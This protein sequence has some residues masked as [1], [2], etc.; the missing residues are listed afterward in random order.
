[1]FNKIK[2]KFIRLLSRPKS[3]WMLS[4][5]F[6]GMSVLLQYRKPRF[7]YLLDSVEKKLKTL[8]HYTVGSFMQKSHEFYKFNSIHKV[9]VSVVVT[10]YNKKEIVK[11]VELIQNQVQKSFS[12]QEIEIIIIDDGSTIKDHLKLIPDSENLI[13]VSLEKFKYGISKCRN[14]GG[15]IAKGELILFL[16]PD[17]LVNDNYFTNLWEDFKCYG[18]DTILTGYIHDYFSTGTEDPRSLYGVWENPDL[19]TR[20]LCQL[21]GGQFAISRDLFLMSG[22][23]DEDLIY[24]GVEDIHFGYKLAKNY[25]SA[26]IIFSRKYQVHHIPHENSAA[27]LETFKSESISCLKDTDF[28]NYIYL[29]EER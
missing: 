17:L 6:K 4:R 27:H 13:I 11:C 7:Y 29:E 9:K 8:E 22:G 16:D 5:L 26:K 24:G 3:L 23:F 19:P 21:S 20:R 2:S 18:R 15:L 14:I 25:E 12:R 28:Y 1:M 10:H